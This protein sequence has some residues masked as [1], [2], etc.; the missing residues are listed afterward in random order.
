M[1]DNDRHILIILRSRLGCSHVGCDSNLNVSVCCPWSWYHRKKNNSTLHCPKIY[2]AVKPGFNMAPILTID[3]TVLRHKY[4]IL[5]QLNPSA[6]NNLSLNGMLLVIAVPVMLNHPIMGLGK[7]HGLI[8]ISVP[9]FTFCCIVKNIHWRPLRI[10]PRNA[11]SICLLWIVW[12]RSRI[13]YCK[14][15]I[16]RNKIKANLVI[17]SP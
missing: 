14:R 8:A 12:F 5:Q 2:A 15:R 3:C 11:N 13:L 1:T 4:S 7:I 17:C 10:R 9:L 6:W 16:I